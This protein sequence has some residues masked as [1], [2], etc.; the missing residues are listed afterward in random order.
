M[1]IPNNIS[2]WKVIVNDEEWIVDGESIK[3]VVSKVRL[4]NPGAI[5][6]LIERTDIVKVII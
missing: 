1:R 4:E 6:D 2:Y 5:I 3:S